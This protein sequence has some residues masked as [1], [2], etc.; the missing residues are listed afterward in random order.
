MN[1][2]VDSTAQDYLQGEIVERFFKIRSLGPLCLCGEQ[3]VK[4]SLTSHR[5]SPKCLLTLYM[6]ENEND[7]AGE[8]MGK[9]E[10]FTR[11]VNRLF[12]EQDP[13]DPKAV[14]PVY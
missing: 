2:G 4:D 7:L 11:V 1:C 9:T 14:V 5:L 8:R 6:A 13:T 12:F 3:N 10:L